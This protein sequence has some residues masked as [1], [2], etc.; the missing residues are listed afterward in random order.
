MDC[1]KELYRY[2]KAKRCRSCS[3]SFRRGKGMTIEDR[4]WSQ[5]DKNGPIIPY[6]GT[7][8]WIWI[9]TNSSTGYGEFGANKD[10]YSAHRFSYQLHYGE[11]PNGFLVC[12]KCDNRP[13]IRP[14]HLFAGTQS[15]N[16]KD[17]YKKGRQNK[18]P[19]PRNPECVPRG[20][21]H[22]KTQLTTEKVIYIRELHESGMS[23]REIAR[24]LKIHH[25][26]VGHVVRREVWKHV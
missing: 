17:M 8:C 23:Q 26:T 20:E 3:Q 10:H 4:F 14:D 15:D 19:K 25:A 12:H 11:I 7:P 24:Q 1:S 9:G 18:N 16:I 21:R 6:I 5:V 13:C 22:H 2:S